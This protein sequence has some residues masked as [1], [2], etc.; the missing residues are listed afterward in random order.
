MIR[1][2][3]SL[4]RTLALVGSLF[5]FGSTVPRLHSPQST[6]LKIESFGHS[7]LRVRVTSVP[8]GVWL[9]SMASSG[10]QVQLVVRT[11]ALIQVADSVRTLD[12]SVLGPGAVRLAFTDSTQ[13]RAG[14][15]GRDITL[16]R[17][18]DG[19]FRPVFKVIP[20]YP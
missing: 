14:L 4:S 16:H 13:A 9:D 11:P 18:G 15:W 17:G 7:P 6:G 2:S 12:V 3:Q 8:G 20:L 5:T 19:R 1:P 10:A